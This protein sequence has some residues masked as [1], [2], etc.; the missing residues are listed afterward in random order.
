MSMLRAG[1]PGQ[2]VPLFLQTSGKRSLVTNKAVSWLN[3]DY[4][5]SNLQPTLNGFFFGFC[6][7]QHVICACISESDAHNYPTAQR[8]EA[9]WMFSAASVCLSAP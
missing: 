2:E 3:T 8:G 6:A 4:R 5:L 1:L 9:M 7:T